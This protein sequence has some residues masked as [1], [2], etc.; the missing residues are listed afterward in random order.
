M[1]SNFLASRW[2]IWICERNFARATENVI[3][4]NRRL[5][6]IP[7]SFTSGGRL[8]NGAAAINAAAAAVK[9]G[10]ARFHPATAAG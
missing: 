6:Q 9:S 7:G 5:N 10:D 2:G 8:A 3:R 4:S 1:A